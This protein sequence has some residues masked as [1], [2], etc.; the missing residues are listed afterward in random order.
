MTFEVDET[1]NV[2]PRITGLFDAEVPAEHE[3]VLST[4]WPRFFAY[5]RWPFVFVNGPERSY[6][7]SARTMSFVGPASADSSAAEV[8]TSRAPDGIE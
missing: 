6:T 5:S 1:S 2:R 8:E 4:A 7:P 3:P